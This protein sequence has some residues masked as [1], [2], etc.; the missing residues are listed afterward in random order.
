MIHNYVFFYLKAGWR[1]VFNYF[2]IRNDS[3]NKA[4]RMED[5]DKLV[6]SVTRSTA[7]MT[8]VAIVGNSAG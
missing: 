2:N 6:D 7:T 3:N 4:A 8:V 5:S 1:V